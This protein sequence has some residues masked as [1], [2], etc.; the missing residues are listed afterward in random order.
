M[1]DSK[2]RRIVVALSGGVD[3]AVAALML[4]RDQYDVS[5]IFMKNWDEDDGTAECRAAQ[6][7]DDAQSVAEV[8]KI[9]LTTIN[10][11]HE[12][13]ERVFCE[14]I[15]GY[16]QGITPNPDML[17]NR[18]IKFGTFLQ[19]VVNNGIDTIATGH[20]A[21]GKTLRDEFFLFR[22]TDKNKDQSYFLS[23]VNRQRLAHC[24]FPL[25]NFTKTEVRKLARKA[26]L[27]V[28]D[29]KDS[30]GLC[31]I[32]ERNFSEFL[33]RYIDASLGEVVD[34]NGKILGEHNGLP[35]YTLG[36]R[37]GI[38]VGGTINGI[39]APWYV[40]EKL[41]ESNRLVVTQDESDLMSSELEA[42]DMNWLVSDPE[43]FEKCTAM[44]RYRQ[45]PNECELTVEEKSVTVKFVH[46]QRAVTP[47]QYV[48]FYDHD[49]CLG[50]AK[51]SR[52]IK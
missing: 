8:L 11:A 21:S 45:Q 7:F 50:A 36:Q 2:Q 28:H 18:E 10:F 5:A 40:K 1:M 37:K 12:Y 42:I 29:K 39:E 34:Q 33:S 32:G 15:H 38:G 16:R 44:V 4:T 46:P 52:V 20:Y 26:R 19:Y 51:I 23:T 17:C 35:Y 25:H 30:T 24:V 49:L 43:N 14:L 9:P 48:T 3:S 13:W 41:Q 27:P 31:F 47:G 6:D 22:G